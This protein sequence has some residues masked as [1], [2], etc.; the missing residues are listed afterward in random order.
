M[1]SEANILI[2]Y[3]GIN[4]LPKLNYSTRNSLGLEI[5]ILIVSVSLSAIGHIA[6]I[7]TTADSLHCIVLEQI[8]ICPKIHNVGNALP[9]C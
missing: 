8:Y 6:Y 1:S 5:M 2:Y 3:L 9:S 4:V 7:L